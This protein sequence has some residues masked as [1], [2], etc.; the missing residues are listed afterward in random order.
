M[1]LEDVVLGKKYK[2]KNSGYNNLHTLDIGEVV[3]PYDI[4]ESIVTNENTFL[5]VAVVNKDSKHY[6]LTQV[7]YAS[8]LEPLE[9]N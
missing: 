1:K 5:A 3:V 8:S 7:I 6:D 4:R 9:E 2:I